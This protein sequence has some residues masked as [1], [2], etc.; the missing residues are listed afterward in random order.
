MLYSWSDGVVYGCRQLKERVVRR[1][2]DYLEG[3]R[4]SEGERED[5]GL[6]L[7]P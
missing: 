2:R 4:V 5:I 6:P 1:W 3:G 7:H